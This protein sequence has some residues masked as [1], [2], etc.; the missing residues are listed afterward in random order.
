MNLYIKKS[1]TGGFIEGSGY[2]PIL[3]GIVAGS[4]TL[5]LSDLFRKEIE[6][7]RNIDKFVLPDKKEI[8]VLS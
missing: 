3:T 1:H 5:I 2:I 7:E 6:N 4:G 8:K